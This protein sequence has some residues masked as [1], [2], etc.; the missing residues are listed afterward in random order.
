MKA[1]ALLQ[2]HG[3]PLLQPAGELDTAYYVA[4]AR[5]VAAG[6]LSAG[7]R[8]FFVS[9]LYVYVLAAVFA[10]T[11]G[12]LL[13]A[14]VVQ[15]VL[16]AAAV[17]LVFATARLWFG[18]RAAR[19]AAGLA[20]LTGS[21]TFNEVI[22][23]QSALDPFLTALSLYLVARAWL[24]PAPRAW[25]AA[26]AVLGLHALNRPNVLLVAAVTGAWLAFAVARGLRQPWARRMGGPGAGRVEP[27]PA[28]LAALVL[29]LGAVLAPVAV[30]N[31]MA[32]GEVTL[33]SS[34]GG[35]NFYIG[36]HAG[37]DGTYRAVPGITPSIAGQARD[38][39]RVAERALG[40]TLTDGEVSAYF[41]GL[42]WE[43]IRTHPGDALRLLARK[44]AYTLNATDV[45]LNYSYAYY[46]RDEPTVLRVLVVGPWL[47]LPLGLFGLIVARPA[48]AGAGTGRL[49]A[50]RAGTPAGRVRRA[51]WP[52]AA[53]VPAYAL[54]VAI[55]FVSE[56]Y[57]LPLL[58]PLCV[59]SASALVWLVSTVRAGRRRTWAASMAL[60]A[61]LALATNWNVGL[62]DG[63]A[64]ERT[65]M[66][67]HLVD[68][69][70]DREAMALL[71]STVPMARDLALVY[72][73]AGQAFAER[74][75]TGRAIGLLQR[76]YDR[77]PD[78]PEIRLVLGQALLDAGRPAEAA[79][80]LL[81][82][83]E[84]GVRSD[85]AAFDLA[86]ARAAAGDR[87]GAREALRRI[88]DPGGL[89]A[90]SQVAAGRLALEVGDPA[91]ALEVLEPAAR[92]APAD[93]AVAEA[94][95]LALDAA[96]RRDA[97]I[98]ALERACALDPR[99]ATARLNLA[100]LLA[101][102]GRTDEARRLAE[103]ALAIRPDYARARAF[104]EALPAR[105]PARP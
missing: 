58:V 24:A 41:Y 65:E 71:E 18:E 100:V 39:R 21:F 2:L 103:G 84:A 99:S 89:D 85:L 20:L 30:R 92:A 69:G 74:G 78:R 36:N 104:L 5:D 40:R 75:E 76:A 7:G 49:D 70:R 105:K 91:F 72:F 29:G 81:A 22:I 17:G 3:H 32:A 27:R 61:G 13:A 87:S 19:L 33:V 54:A 95:G 43:W 48:H 63:R 94:L 46:A 42:G 44:L 8:V 26:G 31:T 47:L 52:W 10:T 56:R 51:W 77:A 79:P 16:G 35:L 59:T 82:A 6:D 55:F 102:G 67:V 14:K 80:H 93:A 88:P 25:F 23:L 53:Y 12:S 50:T 83:L 97:A 34:H 64:A 101:E 62:D 68:A 66:I 60:L 11:G 96:G 38:A 4:L 15:I 1:V 28:A 90:A 86:R 9:P 57:R 37:A 45:A 73:R 98:A